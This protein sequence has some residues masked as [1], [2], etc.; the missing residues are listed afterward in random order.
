VS[1][2]SA[3][4]N[5]KILAF[6]VAPGVHTPASLCLFRSTDATPIEEF[7]ERPNLPSVQLNGLPL[8]FN[9]SDNGSVLWLDNE[10]HEASTGKRITPLDRSGLKHVEG[11][12]CWVGN[13]NV[14]EIAVKE[15]RDAGPSRTL[16]NWSIKDGKRTEEPAPDALA[17]SASPDRAHIAEAGS[18][19]RVRIRNA[20]TLQEEMSLRVHDAPVTGVAWHPTLPLLAT[21]SKDYTVRIWNLETESPVEEIG[22][23][24]GTPGNLY[25]SPDGKTLA[26]RTTNEMSKGRAGIYLFTPKSC[27]PYRK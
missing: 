10:F 24:L 4:R 19:M 11:A 21:A 5:G 6:G 15:L 25:W 9:L 14:V 12:A 26:V 27:N 17:I 2:F 20:A 16:V 18:D 8:S 1:F 22:L 23:F 13:E 3:S 7:E